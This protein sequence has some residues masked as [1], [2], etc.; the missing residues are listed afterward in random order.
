MINKLIQRLPY[1]EQSKLRKH[2]EYMVRHYS[3]CT[4]DTTPAEEHAFFATIERFAIENHIL[5]TSD[6]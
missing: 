5:S 6:I 4:D 2:Y 1:I 3:I